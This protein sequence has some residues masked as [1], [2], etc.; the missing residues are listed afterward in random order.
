ITHAIQAPVHDLIVLVRAQPQQNL[1]PAF[2][3]QDPLERALEP[4]QRRQRASGRLSRRGI[5]HV[6]QG[7]EDM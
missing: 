3:L 5:L 6:R 2:S 7:E 1:H 4:G